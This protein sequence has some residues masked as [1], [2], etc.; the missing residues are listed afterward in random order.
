MC[1]CS[2]RWQVA[3]EAVREVACGT[4]QRD[5][6]EARAGDN[7]RDQEEAQTIT[8]TVETLLKASM[9]PVFLGAFQ[10]FERVLTGGGGRPKPE[11]F[12]AKTKS[13][14]CT[15]TF[16]AGTRRDRAQSVQGARPYQHG[17]SLLG[18]VGHGPCPTLSCTSA[19]CA[20]TR[21]ALR[22]CT[23]VLGFW[24]AAATSKNANSKFSKSYETLAN[25]T[26]PFATLQLCCASGACASAVH[27]LGRVLPAPPARAVRKTGYLPCFT[28]ARG[29]SVPL[30]HVRKEGKI[31]ASDSRSE[32]V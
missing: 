25:A 19:D 3:S 31:G 22:F 15:S 6:E 12:G 10:N 5:Q 21:R 7:D 13:A 28:P 18:R 9:V 16:G 24:P 29:R 11:H 4:L 2:R 17:P 32:R 1:V 23:E 27:T 20:G 14:P 8:R 30:G 26:T